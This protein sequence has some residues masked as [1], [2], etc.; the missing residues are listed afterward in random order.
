M[1]RQLFPFLF[2]F[3]LFSL[4]VFLHSLYG[5]AQTFPDLVPIALAIIAVRWGMGTTAVFCFLAG[6][7]EDSFSTS[8][9]GL[10]ALAWI[11][12]GIA[13]SLMKGSLYGNR[14]AVSVVLVAVLKIIHEIVYYA[15][16]MWDSPGDMLNSFLYSPVAVVYSAGLALVFFIPLRRIILE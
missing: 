6:V 1:I 2:V 3:F 14:V 13:A 7:M 12:A 16:Y 8:F 11:L 4:Q 9:L 5:M 10:N 15:V